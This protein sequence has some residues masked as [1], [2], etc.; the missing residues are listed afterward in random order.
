MKNIVKISLLITATVLTSFIL[1]ACKHDTINFKPES[2]VS[3]MM[4]NISKNNS[5]GNSKK[6][7][8]KKSSGVIIYKDTS[9]TDNSGGVQ[10]GP[11]EIKFDLPIRMK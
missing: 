10:F 11:K 4:K 5:S 6:S 9:N 8:L 3:Q 1:S 7:V 2:K